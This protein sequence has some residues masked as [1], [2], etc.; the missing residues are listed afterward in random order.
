[1]KNLGDLLERIKNLG[2]NTVYLQAFADPD[3]NGAADY[4]YFP[5]RNIPMRADL[6]NRVAWQISTRTQ[7]KRIYA[8]MPMMAWQLPQN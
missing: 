2:V 5:N 4:V 7:V 8:W 3:A 6:F 1:E